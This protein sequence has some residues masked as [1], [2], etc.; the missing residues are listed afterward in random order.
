LLSDRERRLTEL[1]TETAR[2]L[3]EERAALDR[4]ASELAEVR[5]VALVQREQ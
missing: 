5:R 4:R 1:N 2:L 3:S